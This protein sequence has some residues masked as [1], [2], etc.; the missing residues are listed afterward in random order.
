MKRAFVSSS[1]VLIA[2]LALMFG[3]LGTTS[4]NAAGILYVAPNGTGD[5]S[6]W[7]NACDLQMALATAISGDEIWVMAGVYTPG[8]LRTDSFQL[9]SDVSVYGGFTG[10]EALRN[11]RNPLTHVTIL[12]GDLSG[13]D[14]NN[15]HVDEP[16]RAENSYRVV[17]G[18]DDAI[19]DGFTIT[20]GNANGSTCGPTFTGCGGGMSNIAASP[21]V[22]NVT[23]KNNSADWGGGMYN[24]S[25]IPTI[26]NVT[27]SGNWAKW[28]GG[29]LE[30]YLSTPSII[31]STFIENSATVGG[32]IYNNNSTPTITNVTIANNTAE[33]GGGIYNIYVNNPKVNNIILWSNTALNGEQ[34]YNDS[35]DISISDSVIQGGYISG[36]NIITENPMLGQLANYGGF[37]KTIPLKSGS[38]AIDAGNSATCA[39]KDQRGI[40]RP[41]G[42][43][44]DIGAFEYT[45]PAPPLQ[46]VFGDVPFTHW[47]NEW[48]E[49]LYKAGVTSGCNASPL[50]YCPDA[51]ITRAQMAIFILR[52]IHGS[53][54]APPAA[55]GTVFSDVPLGSFADAWIEQLAS[56]GITT[57][58]GNGN[59]C[60][61]A[62][63]TRAEMAIFLLRGKYGSEYTPPAATGT[64]FS[65]VPLGSFADA[66]IEQLALEEIA[67]GCDENN[68]CPSA[69]VTRAEMAALMVKT[70]KLP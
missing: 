66:W 9:T 62:T 36:T 32:G 48:V 12:S 55:T 8:A 35:G 28:N 69:P 24:N 14:N 61:D 29:G 68:Y 33:W 47:A 43:A 54:Y 51:T 11:Q 44:C 52:G 65:D 70:F 22:S 6:S 46:P 67:T 30:N 13:D 18:A 45:E 34:I 23:F 25:S 42:A 41:Q 16:T 60:P 53:A 56:E 38:S 21:K 26:T 39:A 19:L 20:G 27:F 7:A 4:A 50:L 5:C 40:T 57:G 1:I 17:V 37:T 63:I 64:I 3:P 31:N 10:K 2:L 49:K 15:V 59:Y 58:C